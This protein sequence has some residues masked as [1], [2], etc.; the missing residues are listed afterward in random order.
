MPSAI[1]DWGASEW[2]SVLMGVVAPPSTYYIALASREP[3]TGIDGAMLAP[4]EPSGGSVY[5]RQAIA[6]D[7]THWGLSGS[8]YIANLVSI[9]FG[10]PDV[11]WGF[12]SYFVICSAATGGHIYAYGEFAAPQAFNANY[13]VELPIG[14]VAIKGVSVVPS[15]VA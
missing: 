11:D 4:L 8:G 1:S 13:Y 3:G 2:M 6:A 10:T 12:I 15:I 14:A 7:N 5:A 9:P